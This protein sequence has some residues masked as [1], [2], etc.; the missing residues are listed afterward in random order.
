MQIINV[1]ILLILFFLIQPTY[2]I[3]GLNSLNCDLTNNSSTKSD[4]LLLYKGK[5][6]EVDQ[7][8][9]S[10]LN[11]LQ[12]NNAESNVNSESDVADNTQDA[13]DM[14]PQ[15]AGDLQRA[16]RA[17]TNPILD[18]SGAS[19][20]SMSTD[21]SQPAPTPLGQGEK[22]KHSEI[23]LENNAPL[24]SSD[25]NLR[26][27]DFYEPGREDFM[28]TIKRLDTKFHYIDEQGMRLVDDSYPLRRRSINTLKGEIKDLGPV[29]ELEPSPKKMKLESTQIQDSIKTESVTETVP[30][31]QVSDSLSSNTTIPE[32]GTTVPVSQSL[33]GAES[34]EANNNE[35]V[36]VS[37]ALSGADSSEANNNETV[38][39]VADNENST[40]QT[41]GFLSRAYSSAQRLLENLSGGSNS[42]SGSDSDS[43]SFG[44]D[45]DDG[46]GDV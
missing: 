41:Q 18:S 28:E 6:K 16:L 26:Y 3:D 8:G 22:R 14:S 46:G 23:E 25:D 37:Q 31:H 20:S 4:T 45:N 5:G 42:G 44:S 11:N 39:E 17:S 7:G 9:S 1:C 15:E 24:N 19:N 43:D 21:I 32:T 13:S 29:N 30:V 40:Q 38:T 27:E 10:E 12:N 33:S 2:V 34:L 36:P 35:T